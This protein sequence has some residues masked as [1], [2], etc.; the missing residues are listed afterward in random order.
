MIRL[1]L[2]TIVLTLGLFTAPILGYSQENPT[3]ILSVQELF[4]L[5]K[6]NHPTLKVYESD[7]QIAEQNIAV[8]KNQFLPEISTGLQGFYL[9]DAHIIDKDFSNSTRID[10]PHFGNVFSVEAR[11]L[12][13][14]G[15][16]VRNAVEIENLQKDLSELNYEGNELNIKLLSLGYYLDLFKL[17]NQED[18]YLQNIE[19]AEQRLG[20]ITKFYDQGMVTRNDVIRG[21]LQLSNLNLALQVLQN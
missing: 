21:E 2:K 20:N 4:E 16:V 5:V 3:K 13:W 18:V 8:A 15:G 12:I 11:Q 7:I 10:M 17:Y 1:R 9:G 14:K 19:L 6:K